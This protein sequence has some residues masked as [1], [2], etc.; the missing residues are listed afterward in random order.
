MAS[1]D[2]FLLLDAAAHGHND[3]G[4]REVDRL[5]GFFEDFLRLVADYAIGDVD[6][7]GFDR[8]GA[9]AGFGL[10]SA[11]SAVLKSGKPRSVAGEADV[12][13]ELALKHLTGEKQ[14]AAF[15]LEADAV[16]DHGA[17]HGRSQFGNKVAHLIGV[18]HQHELRLLRGEQLL[19]R[20][21]E[22]IGRVRL[23]LRRFDGV[24]LADLLGGNFG[25][26]GG[27]AASD[28]GGF[29]SPAGSGGDGLTGG[30]GLPGDAVEFAFALFDDY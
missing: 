13:G 17:P 26:E 16:A 28:H 11:K 23:E 19:E 21:G 9:G 25:G 27:G 4:L 18:R 1:L 24:D 8:G 14:L 10:V 22:G 6:L 3:F 12:G 5:L 20:G 30:D 15:V 29:E 2:I 7:H